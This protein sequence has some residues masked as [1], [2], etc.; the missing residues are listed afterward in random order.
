MSSKSSSSSSELRAARLILILALAPAVGVGLCRFAYSLL[1]PDMRESLAWSYATAGFMNTANAAGYLSGA[2]AASPI[3]RR[4]GL[5][6]AVMAGTAICVVTLVL[7]MSANV[8][9]LSTARFL[10]GF[11]GAVAFVAASA[12]ATNI[13][14]AHPQRL[15]FLMGVLY[16]GP[17][18]GIFIS[19]LTAPSL[20]NWLGPGSWWIVWG[21]L[22]A[23]ALVLT[24]VLTLARAAPD[25]SSRTAVAADAP[26]APM[27]IYLIGYFFYG[28][29]SIAY[30][31]F[32]IAFVRDAGGGALL[33]SAFWTIIALGAFVSPWLWGSVINRGRG[34]GATAIVTAVTGLGA[35]DPV[36]Q[37]FDHRA[38]ALGRRVRFG[39]LCRHLIDDGVRALQLPGQ[40]LA[41]GD[42]RPHHGVR[43][44]FN[45]GTDPHRRRVGCDRKP[46]ID[47]GDLGRVAGAGRAGRRLSEAAYSR[48]TLRQRRI[49]ACRD[50]S[51]RKRCDRRS[52]RPDRSC[53]HRRRHG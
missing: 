1:L 10:S 53:D 7:S 14:Q 15:G 48:S 13:A 37:Q 39:I 52:C 51:F 11:A 28:A 17:G 41:E 44:R 50:R 34:G 42:R 46:A 38:G 27:L 9:V 5:F 22:A 23:M 8:A 36:L 25:G 16:T 26:I 32:M 4:V 47:A 21:V 40:R 31:T 33:Q 35:A 12:L 20:L 30:M 29:G 49:T 45:A 19:G 6:R 3:A 43:R 24:M 18:I 2:L